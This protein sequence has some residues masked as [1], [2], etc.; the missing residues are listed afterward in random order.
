MPTPRVSFLGFG[1]VASAFSKAVLDKGAEVA[2]YDVNL[3]RPGGM[4]RLEQRARAPGIRFRPLAEAVQAAD[5][6]LST[7]R[8]QTALD[9][10]RECAPHLKP[11]QMYVD[12]NTTS[13]AVKLEIARVIA[14]SGAD[15][16]EGAILGAVGATGAST[17]SL[18]GG[19]KGRGAAEAL[20]RLGLRVVFYDA[21]LG[22]ASRFKML[23]SVFSKGLEALLLEFLVAGRRAGMEQQLWDEVVRDLTAKAP[24][25]RV[26]SNWIETHPAACVRRHHEL[27]EVLETLRELGV[28]PVMTGATEAFFRR[29]CLLGVADGFTERPASASAVIGVLETK[30]GGLS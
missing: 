5:L 11:G 27:L 23:R 2:V 22:K 17:L 10:A 14:A 18:T 3:T 8:P 30:L 7:V 15:F 12:F 28:D 20:V 29:S 16:V 26:A 6:V 21:E 9:A 4:A 24:F 19:E 1:E 13:P 25:D